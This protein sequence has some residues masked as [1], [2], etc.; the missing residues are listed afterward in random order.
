MSP[1]CGILKHVTPLT[2]QDVR[3][4]LLAL[5]LSLGHGMAPKRKQEL[6]H[7]AMLSSPST[8]E[9]A[10]KQ[11]IWMLSYFNS[12]TSFTLPFRLKGHFVRVWSSHEL[13]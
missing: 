8:L 11:V 5:K 9:V 1:L 13:G 2:S 7:C 10:Q 6:G 4:D 3:M 12:F